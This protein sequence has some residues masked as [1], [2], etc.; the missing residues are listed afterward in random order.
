M[1]GFKIGHA[2]DEN[3]IHITCPWHGYEFHLKDGVNVSDKRIK[4]KKFD[5]IERSDGIFLS[6]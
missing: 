5:V 4:L 2:F 1:A 6:V 3:D